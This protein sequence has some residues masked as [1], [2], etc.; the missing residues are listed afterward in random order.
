M[1]VKGATGGP[2][3]IGIHLPGKVLPSKVELSCIS[4]P[5][6]TFQGKLEGNLNEINKMKNFEPFVMV[7]VGWWTHIYWYSVTWGMLFLRVWI[8]IPQVWACDPVEYNKL[9]L[10]LCM[11][12][13]LAVSAH[14]QDLTFL[15]LDKIAAKLQMIIASAISL[16]KI[17]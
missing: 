1:S 12:R 11:C 3:Y 7:A 13:L 10:S 6:W 5:C 4:H 2:L 16:M 8:V 14:Y 17:C 15:L 9:W